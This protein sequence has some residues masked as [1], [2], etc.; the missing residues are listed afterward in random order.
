[1]IC[2]FIISDSITENNLYN[3]L[4]SLNGLGQAETLTDL[5]RARHNKSRWPLGW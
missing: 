4:I 5:K 1:V 2:Y 3:V